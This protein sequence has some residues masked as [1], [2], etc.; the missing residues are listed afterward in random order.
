MC[1]NND[2]SET[3]VQTPM[4]VTCDMDTDGGGWT[5]ILRRRRNVI[6]NVNFTRSWDDYE[7]GFGDLNT[8][9]WLGLRNIRCLTTR[10]DVDLIIDLRKADGNGMTWIYHTFKVAGSNVKY[11][12]HIGEAEG[13]PNGHDAMAYHNGMS[14]STYD[15][16]NDGGKRHCGR[17]HKGGWWYNNCYGSLLTGS[18]TDSRVWQR[19]LWY[20]GTV[21][22]HI[23]TFD[24]YQDVDMKIRPKTCSQHNS[25][26]HT[27][28]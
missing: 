9:F 28:E 6:P 19:L 18:H 26:C 3:P 12:L 2:A 14:F 4:Q 25:D 24:Y 5:V 11:R 16:D 20:D 13:P 22:I 15:N 8:E 23:S 1:S 17:D 7:N 10:D 27:E 21:P